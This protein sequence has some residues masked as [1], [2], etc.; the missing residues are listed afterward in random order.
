MPVEFGHDETA[1]RAFNRSPSEIRLL[2]DETVV[3]TVDQ[4]NKAIQLGAAG[5]L[6]STENRAAAE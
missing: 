4:K 6:P 5:G 1:T 2:S 3:K